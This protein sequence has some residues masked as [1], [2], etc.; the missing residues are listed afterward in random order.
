MNQIMEGNKSENQRQAGGRT[1]RNVEGHQAMGHKS[2]AKRTQM[3][4]EV[5]VS[6]STLSSPS[7]TIKSH[8]SEIVMDSSLIEGS[9]MTPFK[10][11]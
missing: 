9:K 1:D 8:W 3:P 11:D 2:G 10:L 6:G 4:K 7:E 5:K